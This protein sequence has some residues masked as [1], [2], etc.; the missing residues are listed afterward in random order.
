VDG[1]GGIKN[2][3]KPLILH[4]RPSLEDCDRIETAVAI[5]RKPWKCNA[6]FDKGCKVVN[7]Y[8]QIFDSFS[9]VA[10]VPYLYRHTILSIECPIT[11][12]G[13]SIPQNKIRGYDALG[14]TELVPAS[15]LRRLLERVHGIS[16]D[17]ENVD[18]KIGNYRTVHRKYRCGDEE[19]IL[20]SVLVAG[21]DI[22]LTFITKIQA[23]LA[24][25]RA[26]TQ[27]ENRSGYQEPPYAMFH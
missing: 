17:V 15:W 5:R 20:N 7:D 1:V 3:P 19:F 4:R 14:T 18:A 27:G 11:G 8:D 23:Y 22:E 21:R 12:I 24:G 13:G 26:R 9:S 10:I 2:L 6:W 16:A 25:G